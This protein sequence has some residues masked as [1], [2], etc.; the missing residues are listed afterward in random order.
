MGALDSAT[1]QISVSTLPSVIALDVGGTKVDVAVVTPE[2]AVDHRARIDTQRA[3]ATLFDQIRDAINNIS[4]DSDAMI[5]V[6]CGGPMTPE[7][8]TVSPLNIAAWQN[9]P[10]RRALSEATGRLVVIDN[11]AKA[12]A[13]AE[14]RFGGARASRNY[15]AMVV[16][17]GVGGGIVLDGSLLHGAQSN[18]GHLGHVV[19]VEEGRTCG[20]GA[21]GCLEA[22]ISGRAIEARTGRPANEATVQ[23]IARYGEL[24]GFAVATTATLLDVTEFFV[25]GS[26]ALGFGE[27][28]FTAATATARARAGL[29]YASNVRVQASR[30]GGDGPIVG[31]A[32]VAW[33]SLTS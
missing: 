27:P 9:F 26:V 6:G 1:E 16:S 24:L 30:L 22:E 18:A 10:L 2:G 31:A 4:L 7:G 32:C 19:V 12:L 28:F 14:G 13:L 21:R 15:V 20:C 29:T 25:A 17:T 8:E 3:G 33:N 23:E 11:D 5:G